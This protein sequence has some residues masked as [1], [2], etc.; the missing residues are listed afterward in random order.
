MRRAIDKG[1]MA[2]GGETIAPS[3]K[4]TDQGMPSNQCVAAAA[5]MVVKPTEPTASN[6]MGRRLKRNSSQLICTA[7]V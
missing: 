4:P 3:T 6:P 2:S 1:A 7:E 5:V